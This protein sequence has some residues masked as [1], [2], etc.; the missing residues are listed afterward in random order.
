M[1]F[2]QAKTLDGWVDAYLEANEVPVE[3]RDVNGPHWWPI[4]RAMVTSRQVSPDTL[5]EFILAVL[6]RNPPE[7][8]FYCL[9]AG[10]LEELIGYYGA[11][12][13]D[14]IESIARDDEAF[15]ELLHGVWKPPG[16]SAEVWRRVE[17]ARDIM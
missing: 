13:I 10:P 14:R 4:E 9:A 3:Q 17:L 11:D 12:F 2:K 1:W 7:H 8:T 15:R 16:V 6:A 5:W